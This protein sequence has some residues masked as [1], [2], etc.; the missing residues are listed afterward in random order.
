[1]TTLEGVCPLS[2]MPQN[3]KRGGAFSRHNCISS[4]TAR[5]LPSLS[6]LHTDL[7][8]SVS[9]KMSSASFSSPTQSSFTTNGSPEFVLQHPTRAFG[10]DTAALFSSSRHHQ[11]FIRSDTGSTITRRPSAA[12][13]LQPRSSSNGSLF[14]STDDV[15]D[16]IPIPPAPRRFHSENLRWMIRMATPPRARGT[17]RVA[18]MV[19]SGGSDKT[20]E[21]A[22]AGHAT[23]GAATRNSTSTP[24]TAFNR[25]NVAVPV[26]Y[27]T[28]SHSNR[29]FDMT[30]L[31]RTPVMER[32]AYGVLRSIN[33][34][35]PSGAHVSQYSPPRNCMALRP[36]IPSL[37][38]RRNIATDRGLSRH[39]SEMAISIASRG[40][41]RGD[42]DALTA[43]TAPPPL[44]TSVAILQSTDY[45]DVGNSNAEERVAVGASPSP[46]PM[47]PGW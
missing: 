32:T 39:H 27:G 9:T 35:I 2:M 34:A 10:T 12:T 29:S 7:F 11:S 3:E 46:L 18:P 6:Q 26:T 13:V 20:P 16:F 19:D 37:L 36:R 38:R 8:P 33:T 25:S 1:M 5:V 14:M 24:N 28:T 47:F 21:S 40:G 41:S 31:L 30:A 15:T 22:P 43:T 42:D 23:S 4:T 45:Q 17:R 44:P